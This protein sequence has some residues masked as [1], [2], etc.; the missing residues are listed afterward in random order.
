MNT[1]GRRSRIHWCPTGL[2]AFA[3][4]HAAG[5]YEGPHQECCADHV[6]SSYTPSLA[7]L[8]RAQAHAR[9][10]PTRDL[11][12]YP[13]AAERA[14][15]ASLPPLQ[16]VR[17]EVD[18]LCAAA[19][20]AGIRLDP[21]CSSTAT[22]AQAIRA[23]Q[24][25]NIAHI[26]CHGVQ[27]PAAPLASSFCLSDGN[28]HVAAL[29]DLDLADAFLAFL[30][31][32]ETAKGDARQP[33]QTV[34]IAATMLFVGFKS[35]VATMWCVLDRHWLSILMMGRAMSDADGPFVARRF[36]SQLFACETT[37]ADTIA[38]ALDH[39]VTALRESGVPPDRWATFIHMGA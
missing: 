1:G 33:D 21:V 3:P 38:Y 16:S 22:T 5:V 36:Y 24:S 32:C 31:A 23:L 7:A 8:L 11:R 27:R 15:D 29:M 25:A 28:L 9:T 18:D 30:S 19:I 20:G 39:A 2:L 12:V 6:V 13:I 10:L 14:Q 4:L 17:Q 35:V 34:H 37:D 26:A